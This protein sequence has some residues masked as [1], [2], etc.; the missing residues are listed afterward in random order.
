VAVVGTVYNCP[1]A[2]DG[3]ERYR[4]ST[5]VDCRGRMLRTLEG[6][7]YFLGRRAGASPEEKALVTGSELTPTEAS[8]LGLLEDLL[9]V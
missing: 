5:V 9:A 8:A 1:G 2:Y 4:T 7:E 3:A 6:A